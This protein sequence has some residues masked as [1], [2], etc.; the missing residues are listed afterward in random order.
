MSQL[1][2]VSVSYVVFTA[3]SLCCCLVV[4]TS[5]IDSAGT[6]SQTITKKKFALKVIHP[7]QKNHRLRPISAYN[8]S[9]VTDCEKVFDY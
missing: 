4:S 3:F 2:C 9:T 5:A 8:V 7:L 6:D 1:I